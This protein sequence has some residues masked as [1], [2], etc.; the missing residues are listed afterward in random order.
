MGTLKKV[1]SEGGSGGGR[2]HSSM[3]HWDYTAAIKDAA[4][5]RRRQGDRVEV[6]DPA[7]STEEDRWILLGMTFR[8]RLV[9]VSHADRGEII[10]LISA[11]LATKRERADYEQG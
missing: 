3:D 2:G 11:R 6:A 9:V 10:R 5:R 7:H 4:R 1:L 8:G